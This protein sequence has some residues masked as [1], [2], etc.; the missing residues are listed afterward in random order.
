MKS[1]K[2]LLPLDESEF[3][4]QALS[5]VAKTLNP[6][7]SLLTL[8]RVAG[9]PQLP[10]GRPVP[11]MIHGGALS[12]KEAMVRTQS[13][14]PI[15]LDELRAS[16]EAELERKLADDVSKLVDLGFAVTTEVRFGDP[17]QEIVTEAKKDYD[18]IVMATHGRSGLN[19]M[20]MGSVAEKVMRNAAVP[21]MMFK[22]ERQAEK[23]AVAELA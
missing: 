10:D 7:I 4:R 21:V 13:P 23:K 1:I 5:V 22:P 12:P 16:I 18:M 15:Y 14:Y 17:A 6:E 11:P 2:A 3:S 9:Q 19:R 8:L 20:M